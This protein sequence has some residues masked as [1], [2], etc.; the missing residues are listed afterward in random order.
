MAVIFIWP[1]SNSL[2]FL[3]NKI[4][5]GSYE[6]ID[7]A[8]ISPQFA[9]SSKMKPGSQWDEK[10]PQNCPQGW[11]AP[12]GSPVVSVDQD[13][14]SNVLGPTLSPVPILDP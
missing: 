13:R 2:I 3:D 4:V 8:S 10:V 7:D 14:N 12:R 9:E 1:A 5:S 6:K 11:E